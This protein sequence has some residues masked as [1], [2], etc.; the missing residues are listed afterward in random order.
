[1]SLRSLND[2]L[3]R[4]SGR[5]LSKPR[6]R[7]PGAQQVPMT[8]G[9]EIRAVYG[10]ISQLRSRR[11]ETGASTAADLRTS[12][13]KV[14]SQ[15]GEDGIIDCLLRRLETDDGYFMEFGVEDGR[16][17]NTRLPAE[18]FGWSGLYLEPDE[19][20]SHRLSRRYSGSRR[21]TCVN[22]SVTPETINDLFRENRVPE[23]LTVLS[24][25]VDGQDYWVWKALFRDFVPDIVIIEANTGFEPHS[26]MVEA[27]GT[28]WSADFGATFGASLAALR[29]LGEAKGYS[30]VHV[31]VTGVNAFFVRD[32]LLA[33]KGCPRGILERSPNYYLRG[34]A[35][36]QPG[37]IDGWS[38]WERAER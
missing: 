21:V 34:Q 15:N 2:V 11:F 1:M 14:F 33:A 7:V 6:R 8:R 9:L 30:L 19:A 18:V 22:R 12:E 35:H 16:E 36:P 20:G 26:M 24:I 3:E 32:D 29:S 28:P 31:D 37:Q 17:C 27:E 4:L 10:A 23:H 38:I 25:D 13:L 5:R